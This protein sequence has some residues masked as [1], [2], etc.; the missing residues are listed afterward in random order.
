MS[1]QHTLGPWKYVAMPDGSFEIVLEGNGA[2]LL[3]C[4]SASNPSK[5]ERAEDE[6]NVRLA[7]AAPE[8]LLALDMLL[9]WHLTDCDQDE[10]YSAVRNARAAIAKATGS[11]Q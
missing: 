5:E 10:E 3:R 4:T 2:W 9:D 11:A 6:A 1:A 8:L 7:A